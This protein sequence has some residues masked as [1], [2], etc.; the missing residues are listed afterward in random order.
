M[1]YL[2]FYEKAADHA[3][4]EGP[5]QKAHREHVFAAVAHGELLLGGPLGDPFD[6]AQALL[7]KADSAAIAESFAA[8]DPFVLNGIVQS[9]RV[10]TWQTVVGK[11][12]AS[13][14]QL[15]DRPPLAPTA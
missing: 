14:L 12:A 1:H 11:E 9:W 2:L 4:R 6:G 10:R 7:F 13:P 15:T 8:A 3:E 5:H